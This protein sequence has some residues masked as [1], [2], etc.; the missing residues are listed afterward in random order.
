MAGIKIERYGKRHN[1]QTIPLGCGCSIIAGFVLI[2]ICGGLYMT[3]AFLPL[4]LRLTGVESIGSTDT[5]FEN[6][7]PAPVISVQ[8]AAPVPPQVVV[9]LGT[10]GSENITV[11][12]RSYTVVTGNTESG[13][14]VATATFTEE[15]LLQLCA[16]RTAACRPSGDGQFRNVTIDL[17]PGGA[18]IYMDVNT[19]FNWQRIGVVVQLD[20]G[21]NTTFRVIGVDVQGITYNPNTLPLGLGDAV[22]TAINQIEREGNAVLTQLALNAGGQRYTLNSVSIDETHLT[23]V[24]R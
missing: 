24:L 20:P 13:S 2:F 15:A 6:I 12:S 3:G 4:I 19:G 21:T 9:D 8:N 18:V 5:L 23:L 11:D 22:M 14:Q 1:R 16:E 7:Q 17:R 10:Y